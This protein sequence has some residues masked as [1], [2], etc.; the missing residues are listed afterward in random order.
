[1]NVDKE[2]KD[3]RNVADRYKGWETDLIKKDVQAKTF[4][5][6]VIMENWVGDFN[7][8]CCLRSCNA[9]GASKMFY[10]GRKH[11]DRRGTV[12]THH[13]TD[14]INIPNREELLKLKEQYVFVA[15]ENN[16]ADTVA[17]NKF[18]WPKNSLIF[19]GEEGVGLTPETLAMC[20]KFVY[21]EQFGSVRSLNAAAAT[22]IA[23]YDYVN[24]HG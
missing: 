13:Y 15:L 11:Y 24:K 3:T 1:M 6:A 17:M 14:M 8:S 23:L 21:I 9:L 20:D 18:D 10:L 22:S 12:G 2:K 16:I 19:V 4:P 5:F 7:I